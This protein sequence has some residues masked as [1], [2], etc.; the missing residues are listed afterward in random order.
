MPALAPVPLGAVLLDLDGTLIDSFPGI[1]SAYHHVLDYLDVGDMDDADLRQF[2]GP[3]VQEVLSSHFGL[4]GKQLDDAIGVFRTHY[5]TE[6]LFRFEAYPGIEEMLTTLH[7]HGLGLY[8]ATSK[9]QT[10]AT[11]VIEHAGWSELITFVG[12]A[13]PDG[14]R[15]LKKDVIEWTVQN[16][17]NDAPVVAM[18]GDR[19]Q[20][21]EAARAVGLRSI[22]VT[23]GFGTVAEL[24]GAEPS[25]IVATPADLVDAL[26]RLGEGEPR[27]S[28]ADTPVR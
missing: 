4:S 15:H 17:A 5:G 20:D 7:R 9:L 22:G 6:G 19:A 27:P 13:A 23:W 14:S 1:A 12:G 8:I 21:L 3:P 28:R 18:V 25:T 16:I 26:L 11:E 10:M 24:S 2:V